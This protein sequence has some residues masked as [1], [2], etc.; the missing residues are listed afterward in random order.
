MGLSKDT[1]SRDILYPEC[2]NQ[3]S[4]YIFAAYDQIND[5]DD[6]E[7][8]RT[9]KPKWYIAVRSKFEYGH[10]LAYMKNTPVSVCPWCAKKLPDFKL[11]LNAPEKIMKSDNGY[12]CETCGERAMEC[13]CPHPIV[14]WDIAQ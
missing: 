11:N 9:T 12:Y 1:D 3:G 6:L 13:R 10:K 8:L 7:E 4:A 2:C 5:Y 14:L